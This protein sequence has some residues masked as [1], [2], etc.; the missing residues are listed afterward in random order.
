MGTEGKY[1]IYLMSSN[2]SWSQ[3]VTPSYFPS[4]FLCHTPIF[5]ADASQIY[6]VGEW[7]E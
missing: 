7:W 3:N 5:S 1:D 2:G 6:F 4:G